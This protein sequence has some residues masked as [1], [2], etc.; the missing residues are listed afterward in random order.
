MFGPSFK[1]AKCK[2]QLKL[3]VSRVKLLRNKREM[4]VK[5]MKKE[6]ADLLKEGKEP[7]ATI[8]VEHILREEAT[9]AAYDVIELFCELLCVRLPIIE[10]NKDCPY[11]LKEAIASIIFAAPRCAD[12]PELQQLRGLFAA[13]YGKEFAAAAAELRPDSGVNRRIIEKL[14]IRPPSGEVKLQMLKDIA[15]EHNFEWDSSNS[16]KI[17]ME[18]KQDLLDGPLANPAPSHTAPQV[19]PPPATAPPASASKL[20]RE[21]SAI[22]P[23]LLPGAHDNPQEEYRPPPSPDTPPYAVNH[24]G[25]QGDPFAGLTYTV[26]GRAQPSPL[27]PAVMGMP[28]R[29]PSMDDEE[30]F[31][32]SKTQ[33]E[34]EYSQQGGGRRPPGGREEYADVAAA[35]AAAAESADRAAAA[36]RAAARLAG[37]LG[38]E[39][40]QGRRGKESGGQYRGGNEYDEE[41]DYYKG[42]KQ[43]D[44]GGKQESR[45]EPS[46]GEVQA[47]S[48]GPYQGENQYRGG[49]EYRNENQYKSEN[50]Y[51]G[52]AS[53]AGRMA[54][55]GSAGSDG[56]FSEPRSNSGN[57]SEEGWG[58]AESQRKPPKAVKRYDENEGGGEEE[59]PSGGR[60]FAE[61]GAQFARTGSAG[62]SSSGSG[63]VFE[64]EKSK[65]YDSQDSMARRFEE[66][67]TRGGSG[68]DNAESGG[69]Q[70][71]YDDDDEIDLPGPPKHDPRKLNSFRE[72]RDPFDEAPEPPRPEKGS[73]IPAG[74]DGY[75]FFHDEKR[76]V[77]LD[78]VP[79]PDTFEK[80]GRSALPPPPGHPDRDRV[81][82]AATPP[83]GNSPINERR[84]GSSNFDD[85]FEL[86]S[87]PP[88]ADL[89]DLTARFEALK[90]RH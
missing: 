19:T 55:S 58:R 52:E 66:F 5:Q 50:Q 17:L 46:N 77:T 25:A 24:S 79:P 23:H 78:E 8:R 43:L 31:A 28:A 76:N 45:Q 88:A 15:A 22:P 4:T 39:R 11:D 63:N 16:E 30:L 61:I 1:S 33:A 60:T 53:T 10:A 3:C 75:I 12:L 51:R 32:P 62:G 69:E 64:K 48:G 71:G 42:E 87:A 57:G 90:S 74:K 73:Y 47:K 18:P 40:S 80:A 44:K 26:P 67:E 27:G 9:M 13:K 20:T 83:R 21:E 29:T 49:G 34:T 14:A 35:A 54:K 59:A 89:D 6:I 38:G 82:R 2:T 86:P 70:G 56:F 7:S 81:L 72:G 37:S 41:K 85:P 36:A 84:D 68:E 65:K